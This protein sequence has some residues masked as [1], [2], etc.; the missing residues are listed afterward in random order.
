MTAGRPADP[1]IS[2]QERPTMIDTDLSLYLED[3]HRMMR[4]MVR[5][6]AES[7]IAPVASEHDEQEAFPW[8]NA[9]AMAEH[10]IGPI[11]LVVA[12]AGVYHGDVRP[13]T[14][15]EALE[16]DPASVR[17]GISRLRPLPGRPLHFVARLG[18]PRAGHAASVDRA[19]RLE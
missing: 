1:S 4:D 8:E 14:T 7:E 12:N 16:L 13:G 11:D 10:A 17:E 3:H 5:D 6:F 18:P 15:A 9:A 19:P 2:N